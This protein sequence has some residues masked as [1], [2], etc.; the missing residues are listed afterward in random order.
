MTVID[1]RTALSL[2]GASVATV[3]LAGCSDSSEQPES[4]DEPEERTDGETT[5]DDGSLPSYA[6]VLPERDGSEYLYG[7][8]D[9]ETMNVLLDAD[10]A[11][12]V[13]EPTDPLIGNLVVVALHCVF[14]LTLL[15]NSP[16]YDAF[17]EHNRTTDGQETFVFVDGVYVLVGDYDV[18]G[19][20]DALEEWGYESEST[21]DEYAVYEFPETD[22]VVGVTD[23]AYVFSYSGSDLETDDEFDAAEAV[24]RTVATAA[25]DRNAA[26]SGNDE[27]AR[28]LRTGDIAGI[29]LGLSTTDGEFDE[30]TLESPAEADTLTFSFDGFTGARGAYQQLS[31][32]EDGDA[33]ARTTVIYA[34]EQRV[35]ENRLETAF[36]TEADSFE[37][38]RDGATVA[39]EGEYSGDLVE[40]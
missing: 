23:D 26:S 13:E 1:R 40:E 38:V 37:V 20:T 24:E 25:G 7:T 35:D 31:M 36:G 17:V 34:D 32:L 11:G 2:L 19:F 8:I 12:D 9:L 10:D 15:T 27:F 6:G 33:V 14:G 39:L 5:V 3:S 16:S 29:T 30:E 28:L 22:E 4:E 18:D 21:A